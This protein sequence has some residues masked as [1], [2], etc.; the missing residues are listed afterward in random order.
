MHMTL[1]LVGG[2]LLLIIG[3]EFLVRGAVRLAEHAGVSPLLIGLTV[4]GFGTSM[5]ELVTSVQ[6]ALSG[7]PGV[8]V[9][10]IVG[11]Q[12]F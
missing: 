5:P 6:G 4:V 12:P 7:S 2:L 3:A 11:S 10:N 1:M 8:A 9:G